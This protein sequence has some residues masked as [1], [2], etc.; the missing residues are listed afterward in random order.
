MK[1]VLF[2]CGDNS[3]RSL[4]AEAF[5]A[6]F[7]RGVIDAVSAGVTPAG[8]TDRMAIAVMR[9]R[10]FAIEPIAPRGIGSVRNDTID[11]VV[12]FGCPDANLQAAYSGERRDWGDVADP[13]G[14]PYAAYRKAREEIG[15]RVMGL[16]REMRASADSDDAG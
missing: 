9:E 16:I 1:R 6:R 12:H 11:L 5:A 10:G 2:I 7:G 13:K 4:M 15:S 14:E 8:E 3:C